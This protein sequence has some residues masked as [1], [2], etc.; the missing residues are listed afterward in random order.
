MTSP[1]NILNALN[2]DAL[3]QIFE[4][5]WPDGGLRPLSMTCWSMREA[6]MLVLFSHCEVLVKAPV[7]TDR[8]IPRSL[9]P[10]VRKLTL[11]DKCPDLDAMSDSPRELKFTSDP[12]LCGTMSATF[13]K[14]ALRAMPR[15]RSVCL[16]M[17]A[18]EVHGIGWDSLAAV[19]ST[20]QLR[21]FTVETFLFSPREAPSETW[22]DT[23]APITT[24]RYDRPSFRSCLR[25]YPSQQD[26]LAFVLTHLHRSLESLLLP[27][28]ITPVAV[29]SQIQWPQLRELS[30]SGEFHP[31]AGYVA[32]FVSLFSG[33]SRL[34]VLNLALALPPGVHRKQLMLWPEGYESQLPWPDLEALTVSFPDP[35]DGIFSRLPLSLRRL[36]LRCTPHH[37]LRLWERNQYLCYRSPILHASE[38]L[39]VLTKLSAPLLDS[40]QLEYRANDADDDLLRCISDK[41]PNVRSLE[42]QRFLASCNDTIS[43]ANIGRRL[44]PLR[45]LHTLRAHFQLPDSMTIR[46][47]PRQE[48]PEVDER[49]YE[50][51]V[52]ELCQ[53]AAVL[54]NVLP[55]SD[56]G[57]WLLEREDCGGR[58]RLFRRAIKQDGDQAQGPRE[59]LDPAGD[60]GISVYAFE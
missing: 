14:D 13:L 52:E 32:P 42:V 55:Q 3:L 6:T 25:A 50:G 58:W 7:S 34:R 1:K 9:W 36:S 23:L 8:F 12:L 10:Y 29:L 33:M 60:W 44:A 30:L 43:V 40:L 17:Y 38:M 57:L 16:D 41:F 47:P 2:T 26:T 22:V 15:L 48:Y 31:S 24:F 21:T 39:E 59:E 27:S 56:V 51:S 20:P 46:P 5:L 45:S 28:E 37:C 18:Q 11:I 4:Y 53:T 49:Y 35:E 19:L 54:R